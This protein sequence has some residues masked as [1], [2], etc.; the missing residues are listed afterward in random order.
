MVVFQFED[1]QSYNKVRIGIAAIEKIEDKFSM[2]FFEAE[3]NPDGSYY[4]IDIIDN[5]SNTCTLTYSNVLNTVMCKNPHTVAQL[6][7]MGLQK[8]DIIFNFSLEDLT[9]EEEEKL[10]DFEDEGVE[11]PNFVPGDKHGTL[12]HPGLSLNCTV[13]AS[14][15]PKGCECLYGYNL[16]QSCK[17]KPPPR[18]IFG[19]DDA[20]ECY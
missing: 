10:E 20:G 8:G 15:L 1:G 19:E 17:S 11:V 9:D 13:V 16:D 2:I 4:P 18:C 3:Y 5:N 6:S 12:V 7:S 14:P